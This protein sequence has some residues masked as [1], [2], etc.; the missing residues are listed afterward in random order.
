MTSVGSGAWLKP[1]QVET[2]QLDGEWILLN[3]DTH[4]VTKLNEIGGYIWSIV[5][6]CST[7][8]EV[9]DKVLTEYDTERTQVELDVTLFLD[10]LMRIGL[11]TYG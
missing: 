7:I 10:D 9:I 8:D 4:A 5:A 1:E 6:D 2:A 11:L 3:M